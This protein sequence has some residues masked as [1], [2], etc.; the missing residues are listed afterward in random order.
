M[1]NPGVIK[2]ISQLFWLS[3]N[4]NFDVVVHF[5]CAVSIA[6]EAHVASL[7]TFSIDQLTEAALNVWL[8]VA[9]TQLRRVVI[10]VV[11]QG[12]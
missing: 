6:V 3:E 4:L 5:V 12:N 7:G 2:N 1:Q 8:I 9:L 10:V 11:E